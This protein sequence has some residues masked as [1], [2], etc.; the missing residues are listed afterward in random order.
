MAFIQSGSLTID[1]GLSTD[2]VDL[3]L[4]LIEQDLANLGFV[5]DEPTAEARSIHG[6]NHH[7]AAFGFQMVTNISLVKTVISGVEKTIDADKYNLYGDNLGLF[8]GYSNMLVLTEDCVTCFEDRLEITGEWGVFVDFS[9][10]TSFLAK[11]LKSILSSY[12]STKARFAAAGYANTTEAETGQSRYKYD[13]KSY[14][15]QYDS[16]RQYPPFIKLIEQMG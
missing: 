4:I 8:A 5:F 12:L 6:A 2:Q 11:Y 14:E 13:A 9:D 16:I 15:K 10:E 7:Q 3:Q 1:P